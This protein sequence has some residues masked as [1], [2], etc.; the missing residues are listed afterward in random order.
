VRAPVFAA[1]GE[2]DGTIPVATCVADLRKARGIRAEDRRDVVRVFP[3]ADGTLM[4][5]H[6][7]GLFSKIEPAPGYRDAMI[8]W[9]GRVVGVGPSR[10]GP[11]FKP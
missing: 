7:G 4:V 2:K 3:G 9:V 10:R 6:G 1:Y 11:P 5:R 8:A